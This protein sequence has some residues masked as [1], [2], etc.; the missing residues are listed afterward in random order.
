MLLDLLCGMANVASD[1][2]E[3]NAD[4]LEKERLR[5]QIRDMERREHVEKANRQAR[6]W[7]AYYHGDKSAINEAIRKG[8][9]D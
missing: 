3:K 8:Y 5:E 1:Y 9:L 6:A 2:M 4:R 7:D